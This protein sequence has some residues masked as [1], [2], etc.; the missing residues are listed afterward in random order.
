M[1][2]KAAKI[3]EEY[4]IYIAD[5]NITFLL[6]RSNR[7]SYSMEVKDDGSLIL[8]TPLRIS[9]TFLKKWLMEK[10][11]WIFEKQSLQKERY[12]LRKKKQEETGTV[13]PMH[14]AAL[15]KRYRKAAKIYIPQRVEY[16]SKQMGGSYQTVSIREQKTRWGSCSSN[17]TLSFNWRLMLAPPQVLDYV[18]VHELCH[19]THMN[20]S[21]EFWDLV[22]KIMPDYKEKKQWLKENGHLLYEI[23]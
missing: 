3:E 5:Q 2:K 1:K 7:K 23:S 21:K 16:Y 10:K 14:K 20:H 4:S 19:L 13:D 22:E 9:E 15:E 8:R 11:E 12:E 6:I 17:H 18:I